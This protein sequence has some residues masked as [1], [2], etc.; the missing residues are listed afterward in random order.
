MRLA[1]VT[2]TF[3]PEINGVALTV[4]RTV[5][6]LRQRHEV[7][8]IRPRQPHEAR[9]DEPLEWRTQGLPIPVY[10]DL[11]M[12]LPLGAKLAR[13]WRESRPELV[14]VATEGPLGFS[15]VG[16]AR[17]LGIPVTTDFRTNFHQYSR[18]YGL[19]M[20]ES[21]ARNYLR[22][23]H[24]RADRTFVP[25]RFV[26]RELALQGFERLEVI[27]RGVDTELFNPRRRSRALRAAWGAR[28]NATV[29]LYVGRLA[30]EKNV[31]LACDAFEA[32][33]RRVPG[34]RLVMVGDGPLACHLERDHPHAV[35]AGTLRGEALADAYAS[36][37][38]FLFPSMT[39]TFG[40][41]TLEALA[42]GLAVVAF[43]TAAAGALIRNNVSGLLASMGDSFGFVAAVVAAAAQHELLMPMRQ[44]ARS[45]AKRAPWDVV[46]ARFERSLIQAAAAAEHTED[47]GAVLA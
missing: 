40:N 21:V 8:L 12:G 20:F 27:E 29:L 47:V 24:N 35:F 38:I 31:T 23:F 10:R 28:D 13:R 14:H 37:D 15:A 5:D 30:P 1:Y 46:L 44:Q 2:E 32:A 17:R 39:D 34:A 6:F 4:A 11:R 25:S 19:G 9:C 42:S 18:F 22:A 7:E 36:A 33:H 26:R 43:D 45:T 3:P 16:A 41:V